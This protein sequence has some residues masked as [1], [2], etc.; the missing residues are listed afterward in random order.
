M[1]EYM[2]SNE[3]WIYSQTM[4]QIKTHFYY[5]FDSNKGQNWFIRDQFEKTKKNKIFNLS[6]LEH[7]P[8]LIKK[9]EL[10][11][12]PKIYENFRLKNEIY[13]LY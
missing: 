2:N 4:I 3:H 6:R 8:F 9:S 5:S 12:E 1:S 7:G 13:N 11:E 10:R